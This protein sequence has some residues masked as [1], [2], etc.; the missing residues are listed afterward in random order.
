MPLSEFA[1][2]AGFAASIHVTGNGKPPVPG[3]YSLISVENA[4][5]GEDHWSLNLSVKEWGTES[6]R[7]IGALLDGVRVAAFDVTPARLED[8]FRRLYGAR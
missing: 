2:K 5:S 1:K 3:T 4:E 7:E 6:L 8:S